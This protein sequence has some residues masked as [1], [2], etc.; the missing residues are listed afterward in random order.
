MSALPGEIATPPQTSAADHVDA[1]RRATAE[2]MGFKLS[3]EPA[4]LNH[5]QVGALLADF[6]VDPVGEG[7]NSLLRG[8]VD[9]LDHAKIN[10]AAYFKDIQAPGRGTDFRLGAT[11]AVDFTLPYSTQ[12]QAYFASEGV[13]Q[14]AADLKL[15]LG[16]KNAA[17]A[18]DIERGDLSARPLQI[19]EVQVYNH[20]GSDAPAL[21]DYTL[22]TPNGVDIHVTRFFAPQGH[23]AVD[24]QVIVA[25][26]Q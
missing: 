10:R 19:S 20:E 1:L 13:G 16:L 8:A 7:P 23:E 17:R 5:E 11:D 6:P 22:P 4:S 24:S 18:A 12:D 9:A 2:G 21:I 26:H 3:E 25:R 15:A 14:A